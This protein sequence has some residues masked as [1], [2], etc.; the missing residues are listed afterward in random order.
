MS[1]WKFFIWFCT[2]IEISC[3]KKKNGKTLKMCQCFSILGQLKQN[4]KQRSMKCCIYYV[5]NLIKIYTKKKT[6]IK[7]KLNY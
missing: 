3:R 6:I 7:N 5:V 1:I 4:V 2:S